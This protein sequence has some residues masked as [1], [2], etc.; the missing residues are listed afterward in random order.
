MKITTIEKTLRARKPSQLSFGVLSEFAFLGRSNVGKSSLL[1]HLIRHKGTAKVSQTP[2]KT[3]SI[4]FY[5]INEKII[6]VDLPGY[7]YAKLPS[8][9]L[10][11]WKELIE[12]YL[13][14]TRSLKVAFVLVDIRHTPSEK[15]DMMVEWLRHYGRDFAIIATKADKL[16]RNKC[17]AQIGSIRKHFSLQDTE[18]IFPFS[19]KD[20][21]KREKLWKFIESKI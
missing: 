9:V 4:D 5:K 6:F 17:M 1:N 7:G 18:K 12:Y 13:E 14:N 2:G 16:S 3:R 10:A 15:D 21:E 11:L 8:T 19:I 20:G